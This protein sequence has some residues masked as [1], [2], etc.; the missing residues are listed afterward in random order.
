MS[1][2]A[3][4]LAF[5]VIGIISPAFAIYGSYALS[6]A[7]STKSLFGKSARR[8]FRT[9]ARVRLSSRR[10]SRARHKAIG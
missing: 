8:F 4:I 1:K 6:A 5:A 2:L 7:P 9:G 10:L 3:A